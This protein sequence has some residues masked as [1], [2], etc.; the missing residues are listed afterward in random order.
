MPW[1]GQHRIVLEIP[2]N[3]LNTAQCLHYTLCRRYSAGLMEQTQFKHYCL[4]D[5][6]WS[7][8]G[9]PVELSRS[10]M[11]PLFLFLLL[12]VPIIH[13][14]STTLPASHRWPAP[15]HVARP[16]SV[17]RPYCKVFISRV[18]LEAGPHYALLKG[19]WRSGVGALVVHLCTRPSTA[20]SQRGV[21]PLIALPGDA[22]FSLF[23]LH[24]F[25]VDKSTLVAFK[26]TSKLQSC[27]QHASGCFPCRRSNTD[28]LNYLERPSLST[29][30]CL[31]IN[32]LAFAHSR[33]INSRKCPA[34]LKHMSK[35]SSNFNSAE[36]RCLFLLYPINSYHPTMSGENSGIPGQTSP[37]IHGPDGT[38]VAYELFFTVKC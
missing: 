29:W 14:T 12:H 31:S 9:A 10:G 3:I 17:G 33:I 37:F 1:L 13:S 23:A 11:I 32:S 20:S 30:S 34:R 2:S 35:L 8:V 19:G 22:S 15:S 21:A 26:F 7:I 18:C 6:S 24:P 16:P 27:T 36:L 28:L 4:K 38:T 25:C 5:L